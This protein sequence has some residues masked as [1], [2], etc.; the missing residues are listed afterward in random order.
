MP[1]A[2][3][4]NMTSWVANLDAGVLARSDVIIVL[5]INTSWPYEARKINP[6]AL[7]NK[8]PF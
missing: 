1:V 8:C 5:Q 3:T 7:E 4:L 6:G 2:R